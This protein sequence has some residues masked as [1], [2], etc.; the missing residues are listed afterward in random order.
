MT[1]RLAYLGGLAVAGVL[2]AVLGA[3]TALT[4][5]TPG[6]ALLTRVVNE[7][8]GRLISGTLTIGS[9]SGNFVTGVAITDLV[10]RD[11]AGALL[12]S[13]PR[14]EFTFQLRSLLRGRFVFDA[15]TL[16]RPR[17]EI[18]QHRGGRL[19]YEEILRS[20]E[21]TGD[22]PPTRLELRELRIQDGF[23]QI[24]LPWNH[25]GQLTT[26]RAR[27]SALAANRAVA[28]RRIVDGP[29]GL[30]GIRTIE[31]LT[32]H[33][34]SLRI[35][36]P[37]RLPVRAVINSF[38]GRVSDPA[39]DIRAMSGTL[40]T[41]GDSL[42]FAL[43]RLE[44][45]GTTATGRGRVDWPR[46]TLLF[47]AEFEAPRLALAD[48]RFINPDFPDYQGRARARLSASNGTLLRT[49]VTD[50]SVGDATSHLTGELVALA[51]LQR[52]LGFE[53]L[54]LHLREIDLEAVRPYLDTLPMRG[55]LSGELEANGYFDDL[56]VRLDWVF[57]DAAVAGEPLSQLALVGRIST[58]GAAGFTFHDAEVPSADLDLATV[59]NL[60]PAVLLSG[61]LA[62][63]GRLDG[64]WTDA[65]FTGT[66]EHRDGG[67]P[68]SLAEGTFHL[69]TGGPVAW[70]SADLQFTPLALAGLTTTWPVLAGQ[71]PLQGRLQVDGFADSLALNVDLSGALGNLQAR[72]GL[73]LDGPT[74]VMQDLQVF[75]DSLDLSKADTLAPP[76]LLQGSMLLNG[77]V[78]TAGVP[79][80]DV[81]LLLGP[82][83]IQDVAIDSARVRASV[84]SRL[85]ALDS[86]E[87]HWAGGRAVAVGTLGWAA[88]DSGSIQLLIEAGDVRALDRQ[89]RTLLA[90]TADSTEYRELSGRVWVSGVLSGSLDSLRAD[91]VG[92]VDSLG[93]D[94]WLVPHAEGAFAWR[95]G[96]RSAL[97]ARL[98]ADSVIR[99]STRFHAVRAM[100]SGPLDSLA[101]S[102]GFRSGT[103]TGIT[104]AGR[105]MTAA[106]RQLALDTVFLDLGRNTWTL[107]EPAVIG[108]GDSVTTVGSVAVMAEDG[109]GIL[110]VTGSL[111]G[112]SE[113]QLEV[114][115]QGFGIQDLYGLMQR[116]T[117]G[118][119]GD[120]GLDL[121][122][123]GTARAPTLRG[124]ATA[125][126]P[127]FGDVRAP[128]ARAVLNYADRQLESNITFWRTGAPI[129][130]VEGRVP[131][132][133]AFEGAA[134]DRFLPGP[135]AI[136][137]FADSLDMS[138]IEALTPNL[139]R[140][141]GMISADVRAAG[142]WAS[143]E[144]SGQ[145]V[146][147]D[148]GMTVPSLGVRY[149]PVSGTVRLSGD[150][151]WFDQVI[152]GGSSSLNVGLFERPTF[153]GSLAIRG[154]IGFPR[155]SSPELRLRLQA[156]DFLVLDVPDFLTARTQGTVALTGPL[157]Q[158]VLT[159]SGRATSGVLYF[160]D[161][162]SKSVV[163]LW[164]PAVAD[165]VDTLELRR[166]R[167]GAAF[168][169]RFLD[170]LS[171]RNLD[172]TVDQDFWLRSNEANVQLVGSVI[173]NKLRRQYRV[174]GS[175]NTPRGTYS[176][177][178]GPVVREFAV[179][180]GVV[181]YFGTPDLNADIDITATHEVRS[182]E[183]G[184][185]DVTVTA[186]I[187]GTILVP[188]LQLT[189]DI[190]PEIPERD[191]IGLL[192]LGR[193]GG[194]PGNTSDAL[195]VRAGLAYLSGVLSSELSRA[196]ISEG[197]LPLDM[198]EIR[199]PF[200]AG[201]ESFAGGPTQLVAGR[202][203][204]RKWFV[205]LNAGF[206]SDWSFAA[207]NFGAS[208]EYRLNREWRA[209]VSAEPGQICSVS[210]ISRANLAIQR[211]QFGADIRWDREF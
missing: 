129:F 48:L 50:L 105:W 93:M 68:P 127:V 96:V 99:R 189:T 11:T 84:S 137:A 77:T 115:L 53:G 29:E 175:L 55:R 153:S 148:A 57:R 191:I 23:V 113:G 47:N 20:G 95:T 22:G 130:E 196:L 34:P 155:L 72:G 33:I 141:S 17:L 158:P 176:L 167:L 39:L 114:R 208:L 205:T 80:G 187:G 12:L 1:R 154:A 7:E 119:G 15:V 195:S 157:W 211:Y 54:A 63:R 161:L 182:T 45:P 61:R 209:Q 166:L 31:G 207:R 44:L 169:S 8:A 197:G 174:D 82:G 25:P 38:A 69:D 79:E 194:G 210:G 46:D 21:S 3:L 123:G 117:A 74:P 78:D 59:R 28:G 94:G 171:I 13:T 118:V 109:S 149:Q 177:K 124:S 112:R 201:R 87:V 60:A 147:R 24:S 184:G 151:V 116:D 198:I 75:F 110:E 88:P 86:A 89:A 9:L 40:E 56:D 5:T 103:T 145:V 71:L 97:E 172:F 140:V 142:T 62:L 135:I 49:A 30:T 26:D 122:V 36:T 121:R 146:M 91:L 52:G 185:D 42:I 81:V 159:G 111:P 165:L 108:F 173:V 143:P 65:V 67:L 19:N 133:L 51:H 104:A 14:A 100:A 156:S 134:R 43:A 27:D 128:L 192:I 190:R 64:P 92:E 125:R 162:V 2:A 200:D 107:R 4:W 18:V 131:L 37:D 85:L 76:T 90:W 73:R 70:I 58:G 126:G 168:Q 139:R 163:N 144:L 180:S 203:L 120:L 32:A 101:W 132:D 106:G 83:T 10:V 179:Q 178:I 164:D 204:G 183:V 66:M 188:R 160:S 98:A 186:R 199:A 193:L 16:D 35:S 150:S 6:R 41:A 136:R 206:C 170:S 138:V 202:A 152:I 102:G 181:R